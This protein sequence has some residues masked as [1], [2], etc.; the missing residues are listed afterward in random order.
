MSLSY[1]LTTLYP[2]HQGLYEYRR[3]H[4]DILPTPAQIRL[5]S[6]GHETTYA[7]FLWI[8]FIQFIGDNIGNGKYR[9]FTHAILQTITTIHPYF[10]HAYE[11][12]LLLGPVI[13]AEDTGPEREADRAYI[14]EGI[15]HG[16]RGM[17][18]LCDQAKIARIQKTPFGPILW[19]DPTLRNPCL[20]G[21]IPYYI[22]YHYT[23]SLFNGASG[24]LYYKIASMHDFPVPPATKFLAPL[25]QSDAGNYTDSALSFFIIGSSGY[26]TSDQK[27][28]TIATSLAQSMIEKKSIDSTWVREIEWIEK[29]LVDAKDQKNPE[30]YSPTNCY[31]S[32]KR[33]IK[34]IY[35]SYITD[36]TQAYPDIMTGSE[37]L[38]QKILPY[39]P[40]ISTQS[41]Y[42]VKRVAWKWEYRPQ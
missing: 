33:G 42:T 5:S 10:T 34:Q 32:T 12:D 24:S 39:I 27:C 31:D 28:Q 29:S 2:Y 4:P 25:A 1:T 17:D 20:S 6:M 40:A 3:L 15:A 13:F 16:L 11:L 8:G 30:S 26:D 18:I 41:G 7:D 14:R 38:A 21:M 9:D 22:G 35:L 36:R 37:L 23:S 19:D